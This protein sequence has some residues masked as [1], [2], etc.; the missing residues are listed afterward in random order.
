MREFKRLVRST[1]SITTLAA[2]ILL[3]AAAPGHAGHH[4]GN[5]FGQGSGG[6]TKRAT[7]NSGRNDIHPV[8]AE[9]R[10]GDKFD[11]NPNFDHVRSDRGGKY[12]SEQDH[13]HEKWG[14]DEERSG[15]GKHKMAAPGSMPTKATGGKPV[16]AAGEKSPQTIPGKP[17]ASGSANP[18]GVTA[19]ANTIHPI[20]SL[21]AGNVTVSNGVTKYEIPNGAGGVSAYS[22][23][24]GKIT[25]TN[26][27]D[28]VTLN[29]G[30]VTISGN[31][32]GVGGDK[33]IQVGARNGEGKTV[34]SVAPTP[35][36]PTTGGAGV[37][38]VTG[39]DSPDI[40][41]G[42]TVAKA[43]D[44]VGLLTFGPPVAAGYGLAKGGVKGA[45]DG[46]KGSAKFIEDVFTSW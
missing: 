7:A 42:I 39:F 11:R 29:G 19:P 43:M 14:R 20:P 16:E 22:S 4:G 9:R 32:L 27:K 36:A 45:V 44:G 41:V 8:I 38:P 3:L 31:A 33:S 18:V 1:T 2:G 25:V 30:T 21:P 24:P 13:K 40:K 23:S 12:G 15:D 17:V 35:V 26:G 5:N 37:H 6:D 46:V 10:G 28:S 34:V